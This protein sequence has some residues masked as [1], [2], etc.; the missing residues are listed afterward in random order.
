MS[1]KR[2][3]IKNPFYIE[4]NFTYDCG[5]DIQYYFFLKMFSKHLKLKWILKNE[6]Q[7]ISHVLE[8][9]IWLRQGQELNVIF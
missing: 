8:M 4:M 1:V 2:Y 6:F 7:N 5:W 9:M 3:K